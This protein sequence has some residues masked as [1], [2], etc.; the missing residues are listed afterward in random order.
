MGRN[1]SS[2]VTVNT[3]ASGPKSS[4]VLSQAKLDQLAQ[5]RVRSLEVRRQKQKA[6]LEG[7]L[8]HLRSMLG[9][10]LRPD[11]VQRVAKEMIALEERHEHEV[12]RLREKHTAATQELSETI[13]GCKDELRSIRKTLASH[14]LGHTTLKHVTMPKAITPKDASQVSSYVSHT[15]SR[16]A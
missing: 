13:S 2:V 14:T 1:A 8:N 16:R 6:K 4:K 11:T 9:A 12:E 15:S 3:E 10:D 5:A 7:K